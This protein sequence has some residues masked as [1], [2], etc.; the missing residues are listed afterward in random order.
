[1]KPKQSRSNQA[2][3]RQARSR[4]TEAK[5][6]TGKKSPFEGRSLKGPQARDSDSNAPA[7]EQPSASTQ[8]EHKSELAAAAARLEKP[9][10]AEPP[11]ERKSQ[12]EVPPI[13]LEGDEPSAVPG[14]PRPGQAFAGAKAGS[15]PEFKTQEGHLPEAYGTSRVFLT[16]RDPWCLCANWDLTSEQLVYYKGRATS[17]QLV[18]RICRD[19]A[20]G[21]QVAEL[22]APADSRHQFIPVERPGV[23]YAVELG[24]YSS[25]SQWHSISVSQPVATPAE[26]APAEATPP[27]YVKFEFSQK[28]SDLPQPP[29]Q[30]QHLPTSQETISTRSQQGMHHGNPLPFAAYASPSVPSGPYSPRAKTRERP[31]GGPEDERSA[32]IMPWTAAQERAL[33]ELTRFTGVHPQP[34]S[35]AEAARLG[36]PWPAAEFPSPISAEQ[37]ISSPFG[38]E[39]PARLGFWLNVNAELVVYGATDPDAQVTL[40]GRPVQLR[41]DG[42]FSCRFTLP[43]GNYALPVSAKAP[44]GDTRRAE[45]QFSRRTRYEAEVGVHLQ[46]PALKTPPSKN[47]D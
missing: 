32:P 24:Y 40:A 22:A 37:G 47:P 45:L 8:A 7:P 17:Q 43:D 25:A 10:P 42:S 38:G 33:A 31:V 41:P 35:S 30:G 5:A 2:T 21:P 16:P 28:A 34:P 4:R 12:A 44:G 27:K 23:C 36:L 19:R 13:L 6:A 1:M 18:L 11:T 3:A 39:F 26:A 9:S 20:G 46:D 15:S 14:L 29:P